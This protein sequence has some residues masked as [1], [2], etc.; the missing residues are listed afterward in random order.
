M[1]SAAIHLH[2]P[3]HQQALLS[4][5]RPTVLTPA[6]VSTKPYASHDQ[7]RN[8]RRAVTCAV[9]VPAQRLVCTQAHRTCAH[10][11]RQDRATDQCK[12]HS[13]REER[14]FRLQ[15]ARVSCRICDSCAQFNSQVLS[16]QH[17]EVWS[18]PAGSDEHK[19]YIKDVKSSNGT[20]INGERLSLEGHS[21]FLAL[22][23]ANC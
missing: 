10:P 19:I 6:T 3:F 18:A 22:F 16:R 12:D 14:V 20:F 11:A 23:L 7:H 2:H 9:P 13:R 5:S 8:Q 21:F 17:A 15:S 4:D 1:I